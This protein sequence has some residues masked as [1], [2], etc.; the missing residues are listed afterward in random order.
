MRS[1]RNASMPGFVASRKH[2]TINK[3]DGIPISLFELPI[4]SHQAAQFELN[5]MT[6]GTTLA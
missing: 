1:L 4:K 6:T 3:V 2:D 5:P